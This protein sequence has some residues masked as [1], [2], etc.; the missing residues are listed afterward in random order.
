MCTIEYTL[1]TQSSTDSFKGI[2]D[3]N[4]LFYYFTVNSFFCCF[5]MAFC[6]KTNKKVANLSLR[7]LSQS[8]EQTI[9]VSFSAG[10][11]MKCFSKP[12]K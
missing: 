11:N 8:L 4:L 5:E 9:S 3:C 1:S 10:E 2:F 12:G 6:G 7:S